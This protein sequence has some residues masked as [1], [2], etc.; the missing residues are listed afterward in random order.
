MVRPT[1]TVHVIEGTEH[2]RGWGCR[3]D[4]YVAFRSQ[5]AAETWIREYVARNHTAP[6]A[7]DEYTSYRYIGIRECSQGFL[8][9]VAKK[10]LKHFTRTSELLE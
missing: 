1:P 6:T 7:P 4:G 5:E 8:N 9:V 10:G 3:P 2:E